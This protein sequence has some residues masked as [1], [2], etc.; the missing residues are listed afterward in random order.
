MDKIK[1]LIKYMFREE[2]IIQYR[3]LNLILLAAFMGGSVS[4]VVS[5]ILKLNVISIVTIALLIVVVFVALVIANKTNNPRLASII[6]IFCANMIIFPIMYFTSGGM[7]SGMPVWVVLG[8]IFSWLI[9]TGKTCVIMYILSV[10]VV[11]VC[12]L[13]EMKYPNIVVKLDNRQAIYLDMLQSMIVVT[14]I[15]GLIF[16]Y[17][18]YIYEKQKK[19][20]LKA[21]KVKDDFLTNMSNEIRTPINA[22]LGYNELIMNE[23][24]DS[25]IAEYSLKTQSAGKK[26]LELVNSILNYTQ[27][28]ELFVVD[29]ESV[30][31]FKTGK[32]YDEQIGILNDDF[33]APKARL[34][35]VDD[36]HFN[37][38]LLKGMLK[39][40]GIQMDTA[41]NGQEAIDRVKN[42]RYD[43]IF[44]DHMMPVMD[45]VKALHI[46]RDQGLCDDTKIIVLT[47]NAVEDARDKYLNEGF[48]DYL[49]KP[50][51]YNGLVEVIKKYLPD[52]L[53]ESKK[54]YTNVDDSIN[55]TIRTNVAEEQ[56]T[57]LIVDDDVVNLKIAEKL[58]NNIY[59]VVCVESGKA[60]LSYLEDNI[61]DIILLDIHMPVMS[62]LDVI[63]EIKKNDEIKD[64]PIIFLTADNDM[65]SEVECFKEGAS[66]FIAKPFIA[67]IMHARI[68]RLL[69]LGRLQ[70][71]LEREVEKQ[72]KRAEERREKVERL[73]LEI[74]H[75]LAKTIDAKDKYTNG[76]SVRVAEYAMEI[77]RRI[78]KNKQ[79]QQDIYF[80]G[81]LHDIGKI[82]IPEAIINKTTKLTDEEYAIIKKHPLI[83]AEILKNM[84]ELPGLLIGA[85]WHHEMYDGHGYPDGLKGKDIPEIARIIG[86]ADAYDAMT[87]RRSYRD[88]LPQEVV[89]NEIEKGKGKQFDPEFA[90][91]MLK[92]IAEDKEYKLCD[93]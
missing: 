40:S 5:I 76:H 62:G 55:K 65:E 68:K 64:I 86:V 7:N 58:L 2:L 10:I 45:G 60:A 29:K 41:T 34:L 6:T 39:R 93:R 44:M 63:K 61:P 47:A 85:R 51:L 13:L 24:N 4:L 74:M 73:S 53:I 36:N 43:I 23:C 32:V 91:V 87:S 78:G 59:K 1:K 11:S 30:E 35:L 83:G 8:M 38:E 3:L 48:N 17:Q 31:E 77:A 28:G 14:C 37:L 21:N 57:I 67:E 15:F 75:T 26:L 79:E 9:L 19:E 88:V 33:Y 54:A 90:N 22:V 71:H 42:C 49:I 66:D 81:L 70:K 52:N 25:Q 80:I 89:K 20:I 56:G 84:T 82:G 46:I 69:E 50:V 12:V 18:T 92:M 72:T 27:M 16:K